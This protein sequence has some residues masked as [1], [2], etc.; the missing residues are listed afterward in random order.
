[1]SD[2][3]RLMT[4][5]QMKYLHYDFDQTRLGA[6]HGY[7]YK[8]N[9]LFLSPRAGLT[10]M[11]NDKVD[12]FAGF[13]VSSR[14]PEDVT[15]YDAEDPWSVPNLTIEEIRVSQ[16]YDSTFIFGDPTVKPERIYHFEC[17]GNLKGEK[18][19]L[20]LNLFWMEFRNEIIPQGGLD[21]NGNPALGNAKRS[22]HSGIELSGRYLTLPHITLSGN[23]SLNDNVLKEYYTYKDNGSGGIDTVDYSGNPTAGFPQY[24]A[25]FIVDYDWAP[26]RLTYR[27]RSVGRQYVEHGKMKDLSIA[28][29]IVSSI[30]GSVSLGKLAGFGRFLLS[31]RVDNLFNKKYELSGYTYEDGGQIYA[32]YFPA[33]ERNFF[34]QLKWELE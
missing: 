5:L 32:E 9:W 25:N 11:P 15:I 20:G 17:G 14:E 10:F 3:F 34:I 29:Y 28:P 22:V 12:L 4:N 19:R 23:A 7:Q 26:F 2:R 21:D 18:Y 8:L 24:L 30:S 6:L 16:S 1:M 33:A 27:L 13:A 31:A